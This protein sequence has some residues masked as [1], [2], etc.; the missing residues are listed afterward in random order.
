MKLIIILTLFQL[1]ETEFKRGRQTPK[2]WLKNLEQHHH[3]IQPFGGKKKI[4]SYLMITD[5]EFQ[6]VLL[7][8]LTDR[9]TNWAAPFSSSI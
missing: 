5:E 6:A 9:N 7:K 2:T 3:E 4:L 8:N 1:D